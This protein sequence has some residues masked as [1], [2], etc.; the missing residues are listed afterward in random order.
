MGIRC[1][2]RFGRRR[3]ARDF[4]TSIEMPCMKCGTQMR[5]ATIEPRDQTLRRAD[6]PLHALRFRR[7]L[8]EGPLDLFVPIK[9]EPGS[10]A[11]TYPFSTAVPACVSTGPSSRTSIRP[12]SVRTSQILVADGRHF[13][14]ASLNIPQCPAKTD[15]SFEA[16]FSEGIVHHSLR[17]L[18]HFAQILSC[19]GNFWY[20]QGNRRGVPAFRRTDARR[21]REAA[22]AEPISPAPAVL[23]SDRVRY[24]A[25]GRR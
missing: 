24:P 8:P 11:G 15:S 3:P 17:L 2:K 19:C 16:E 21:P 18:G 20:A 9:S 6:L 25:T 5:L 13:Q 14:P 22:V 7:E 4:K 23:S 10:V 1:Y 12:R